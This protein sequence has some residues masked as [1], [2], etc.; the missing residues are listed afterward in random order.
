M[1]SKILVVVASFL[2]GSVLSL[3]DSFCRDLTD[4]GDLEYINETVIVC[5]S[6]LEKT[7]ENITVDHCLD[8]T[9]IE[10]EVE[11]F[12]NCSMDWR[13]VNVTESK[14]V[15]LNKT[16]PTCVKTIEEEEHN[17][18][19]YQCRNVTKQHCTSLW[20]IV[21]G[22]KV[23]AG[24][25]DD[26]KDVTWEECNPV[27]VTVKWE[28]PVMNC[29]DSQYPYLSYEN[30]TNTIMADSLDC[31]VEK[32]AVCRPKPSIKCSSITYTTCKEEPVPSCNPVTV[33]C[34]SKEKLH[35]QF[36]LFG[37]GETKHPEGIDEIPKFGLNKDGNLDWILTE[38]SNA[39]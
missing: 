5:S 2:L 34:P 1:D 19:H 15:T 38:I 13:N 30:T 28:V 4:Y 26:C 36:C 25:E 29:T 8:V 12:S 18:T 9:E 20:K 10:C 17:K 39:E 7:C 35:K 24:N 11:L 37:K 6:N 3:K 22:E 14:P 32:R 33:P 21:D 27:P 31:E 23:W 16:L